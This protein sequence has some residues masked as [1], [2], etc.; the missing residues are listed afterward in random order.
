LF[1]QYIEDD[2][3]GPGLAVSA[4]VMSGLDEVDQVLLGA[5]VGIDVEVVI[6]VVAV[7]G[8]RIIFKHWREPNRRASEPRNVV[9]IV[10]NAFDLAAIEIV[11]CLDFRQS[12]RI[13]GR[14]PGSGHRES[15][16]PS[17]N[18]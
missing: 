11:R 13:S 14:V 8:A 7:I 3:D 6:D 12:V 1:D 9:Q 15:G 16:R 5:E 17:E 10:G 4:E 2:A 18:K